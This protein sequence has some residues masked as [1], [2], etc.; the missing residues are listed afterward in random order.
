[1]SNR[2]TPVRIVQTLAVVATVATAALWVAIAVSRV[3]LPDLW[4]RE[5]FVAPAPQRAPEVRNAAA[6]AETAARIAAF[7]DTPERLVPP[8]I[9][10]VPEYGERMASPFTPV[11]ERVLPAVVSIQ[12]YRVV[13]NPHTGETREFLDRMF[14][15]EGGEEGTIEIPSSGSGFLVDEEG[16]ILTN[17]HVV[18]GA[19]RVEVTLDDGRTYPARLLGTDPET[20][21]AVIR[22][23]PAEGDAPL[24]HLVL[25]NSDEMRV[26]DWAIAV[27]N[28]LGELAGTFTVGV[29]SATGRRSL[30]IAGGGP[31]YQDFLQTDASINF[32]NSGGPLVNVRGEVI[33]I[34][35]A[36]NPTGQGLGFAIPINMARNVAV[37]LIRSGTVRRGYLGIRPDAL[38]EDEDPAGLNGRP[39][40]VVRQVVDD[41]PAAEAGLEEGDVILSFNEQETGSVP[42]FMRIVA[43]AGVGNDVPLRVLRDGSD[44]DLH[45]VLA[46][47]PST[48]AP[49]EDFTPPLPEEWLGADVEEIGPELVDLFG[50]ATL[51]GI[52]VTA[53]D[54]GRPAA[55]SGLRVG[56]VITAVNGRDVADV[57]EFREALLEALGRTEEVDFDLLRGSG[58][59]TVTVTSRS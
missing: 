5:Q 2:H 7:E 12:G 29:L 25:G 4:A 30:R 44:R 40:I 26:G 53:I 11:A 31:T 6:E 23:E 48:Q 43:D 46:L 57:E 51:E 37:E 50:L 8:S 22:I 34:N 1:M 52:V 59:T 27:G 49:P 38:G 56:D 24:P 17:D 21:V 3:D 19:D 20:D 55:R 9:S 33:G 14:R 54:M 58:R 41:T 15:R 10:R 45:V 32:G 47:R 18:A 16:Y 35:S 13:E 39:G 36:V 42:D 28:P